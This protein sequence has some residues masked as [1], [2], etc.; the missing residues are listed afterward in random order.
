VEPGD[1]IIIAA[2][3]VLLFSASEAWP[4]AR[5][6]PGHGPDGADLALLRSVPDATGIA[7]RFAKV[8]V[9]SGD[10]IFVD[11][12]RACRLQRVDVGV[13][14]RQGSL[15]DRLRR[16]ASFVC[17]LPDGGAPTIPPVERQ[18]AA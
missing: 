9:G 3:P 7:G 12:V 11:F 17:P 13:V 15:S 10:G 18:Y 16:A 6:L 5:L 8:I 14:A 4:G 2:H 1:H